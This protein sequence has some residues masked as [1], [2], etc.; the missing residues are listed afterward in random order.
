MP[1]RVLTGIL[2]LAPCLAL[3]V[4]PARADDYP[5]LVPLGTIL[6]TDPPPSAGPSATSARDPLD[7]RAA[8]LRARA[9]ALRARPLIDAET[10]RRMAAAAA[11]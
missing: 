11:R 2:V 4:A 9:A 1:R 10:R 8:A 5:R 3:L 7:A 6:P